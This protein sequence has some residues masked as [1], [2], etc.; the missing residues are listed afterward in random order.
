MAGQGSRKLHPGFL[1]NAKVIGAI[2]VLAAVCA[3]VTVVATKHRKDLTAQADIPAVDAQGGTPTP[4]SP[5]YTQALN[6]LNQENLDQAK[7]TGGTFVPVLSDRTGNT[8][9]E[10]QLR[11]AGIQ[12]HPNVWIICTPAAHHRHRRSSRKGNNNCRR[13]HRHRLESAN[14][15]RPSRINGTTHHNRKRCLDCKSRAEQTA[16]ATCSNS[17]KSGCAVKHANENAYHQSQR[18]IL[19]PP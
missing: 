5:H 17:R 9:L 15:C 16:A 11:S 4:E 12:H 2:V 8:Q 6:R 7:N 14:R 18:K 10:Q 13:Y 1:R 19:R 3:V